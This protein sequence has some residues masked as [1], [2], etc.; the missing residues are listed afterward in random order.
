MMK[1][2]GV[3]LIILSVFTA[4]CATIK[5]Q[6]KN[7]D[8]AVDAVIEQSSLKKEIPPE[9]QLLKMD[10]LKIKPGYN[11]LPLR[12]DIVR[13]EEK[14]GEETRSCLGLHFKN[15]VYEPVDYKT[16]G[17]DLGNGLFLDSNMN[18]SLDIAE[19]AGFY[20]MENSTLTC[21][22]DILEG[23]KFVIKKQGNKVRISEGRI[24]P[25]KTD[26]IIKENGAIIDEGFFSADKNIVTDD[27]S[28]SY[29]K[30]GLLGF[31][32]YEKLEKNEKSFWRTGFT[33][34]VKSKEFANT[35]NDGAVNISGFVFPHS[36]YIKLK[37]A[38]K[39]IAIVI[40]GR[41]FSLVRTK[42]KILFYDN[43]VFSGFMLEIHENEIVYTRNGIVS[44]LTQIIK[45]EKN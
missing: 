25:D 10:Q 41:E 12:A 39:K 31:L 23:E 37:N 32:K 6:K 16:I 9:D 3:L 1:K 40:N 13:R 29:K 19:A 14:T 17:L 38:G 44:S 18:L 22:P 7:F 36:N 4:G 15:D 26:V 20:K 27:S 35:D 42:D 11:Y 43:K 28:V 33:L 2:T 21:N 8:A 30:G 45:I 34:S 5:D 24:W